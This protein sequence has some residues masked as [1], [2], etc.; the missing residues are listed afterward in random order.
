MKNTHVE[1]VFLRLTGHEGLQPSSPFLRF[2]CSLATRIKSNIYFTAIVMNLEPVS[3]HCS[4][5]K[6]SDES[7]YN[8][9]TRRIPKGPIKLGHYHLSTTS[10]RHCGNE[11]RHGYCYNVTVVVRR[12]CQ[13]NTSRWHSCNVRLP[14]QMP[15]ES[16]AQGSCAFSM[17]T[18]GYALYLLHEANITERTYVRT[19]YVC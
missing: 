9:I 18:S 7:E 16:F 15:F 17:L 19:S 11:S 12:K 5:N 1:P 13:V 8:P 14:F 6:Y 2:H 4:S 3:L 10:H